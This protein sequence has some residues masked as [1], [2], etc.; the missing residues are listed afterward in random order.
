[1]FFLEKGEVEVSGKDGLVYHKLQ[2]GQ[3]FGESALI[4]AHDLSTATAVTFCDVFELSREDFQDICVR[5][6]PQLLEQSLTASIQSSLCQT[7]VIH[8]NISQNLKERPKCCTFL[9]G[10]IIIPSH[11]HLKE[12]VPTKSEYSRPAY[13]YGPDSGFRAFWDIVLVFVIT[14]NLWKIP[15]SI[16]FPEYHLSSAFNYF[17]DV[18]L[19]LD[20]YLNYQSFAFY[21]ESELTFDRLKVKSHYMSSRFKFDTLA[22]LPYEW[23]CTL[24]LQSS[25]HASIMTLLRVPRMLWVIRLPKALNTIFCY[26][27]DKDVNISS[28]KLIEFLSGVMMIAHFAAVGF[29]VTATMHSDT[30]FKCDTTGVESVGCKWKGTWIERQISDNK[31]P[32]DGG[33]SLQQYLRAFNWSLPTLVVG[34][35]MI[36]NS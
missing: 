30:K 24:I 12:G 34:K 27:E 33:N 22:T 13:M 14:F 6:I 10:N 5:A 26:L 23:L 20:M 25:E 1:M 21:D 29:I 11:Q 28:L 2:R 32:A 3:Y 19:F 18:I 8:N 7:M 15:F 9:H 16:A 36:P 4:P 31:L 35:V 17:P